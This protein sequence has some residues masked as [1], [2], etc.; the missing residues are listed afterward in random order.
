MAIELHDSFAIHPGPWMLEEIVKPHKMTVSSTAEHLKVR[1][2]ALSRLLNGRAA[3][4]PE[5][6]VRFEK[7]FGISAATMLRIQ[8][9]YD[10][11]QA[12]LRT[13]TVTIERLPY[14]K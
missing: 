4:T 5:M 6:A 3:L 11:A 9:D 13:D 14:P 10:L 8:T 2:P 1:R 12:K 7:A